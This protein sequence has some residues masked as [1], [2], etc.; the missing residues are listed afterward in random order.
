[1]EARQDFKDLLECFNEHEVGCLIIGAFALRRISSRSRNSRH[2]ALR[3]ERSLTRIV[4]RSDANC[5]RHWGQCRDA[6]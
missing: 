5:G 3:F 4:R 6:S 1:M 2:P